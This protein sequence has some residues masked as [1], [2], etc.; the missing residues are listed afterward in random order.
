[1]VLQK[2]IDNTNTNTYQAILF[3]THSQSHVHLREGSA[4]CASFSFVYVVVDFNSASR[5]CMPHIFHLKLTKFIKAF[6]MGLYRTK[7]AKW[8]HFFRLSRLL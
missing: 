3:S 7:T 6:Y 5:F 2:S 8:S 4:G 1:M